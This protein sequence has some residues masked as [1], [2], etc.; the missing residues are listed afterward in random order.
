M[1]GVGVGAGV[2]SSVGTTVGAGVIAGTVVGIVV[3]SPTGPATGMVTGVAPGGAVGDTL[4]PD[5]TVGAG[6]AVGAGVGEATGVGLAHPAM[7]VPARI[8]KA[9]V[10]Q[11]VIFTF[12]VSNLS[13]IYL[14]PYGEKARNGFT[15]T[16]QS[17][18]RPAAA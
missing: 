15:F 13:D 1:T 7:M 11:A 3:G 9:I 2:G 4:M 6:D 10:R 12:I 14:I 16:W 18:P 5:C 17:L 8:K